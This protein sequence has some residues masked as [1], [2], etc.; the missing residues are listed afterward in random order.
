MTIWLILAHGKPAGIVSW[1]GHKCLDARCFRV[2]FF[3]IE[4]MSQQSQ[5]GR[6]LESRACH[7]QSFNLNLGS[8][9]LPGFR[10]RPRVQ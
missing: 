5:Q 7:T 9:P 8:R 10:L 6:A 1:A 4:R 2:K 3:V